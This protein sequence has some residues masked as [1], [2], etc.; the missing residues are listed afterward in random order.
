M[1]KNQKQKLEKMNIGGFK[2]DR[3]EEEKKQ[4]EKD[5][6]SSNKA[7]NK[8][9]SLDKN[10]INT[11]EVKK[12]EE[13]TEKKQ[14]IKYNIDFIFRRE[15]YTI[16]NLFSNYL[17]SRLKKLISKTISVDLNLL[18]IYYLDKEITND[19]LN[20]YDLIKDN[21]IKYF[22]VKKEAPTNENIMSLNPNSNFIYKVKC[23]GIPDTKD[24][25]DKIDVFFREKCLDKHYICEPV[26][27][28]TYDVG[29]SC[30][31][32]C[33]QFKRYMQIVRRLDTNYINSSYEYI[34]FDKSKI[35]KPQFNLKPTNKSSV[36]MFINKG[37]YITYEEMQRKNEKEERKKWV[38]KKD[39][40]YKK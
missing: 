36:S 32:N 11:E 26:A 35:L 30:E 37:P 9:K 27:L 25:I 7:N 29:F 10:T 18:H 6:N 19:K 34:P 23:K 20:V 22:E 14:H 31:D 13:I 8:S 12:T 4:N 38:C 2:I 21:V 40:V 39:F 3:K 24:F 5:K 1:K 15:R 28:N 17:V 33:Y 16:K